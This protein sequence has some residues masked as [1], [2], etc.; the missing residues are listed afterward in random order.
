MTRR[1]EYQKMSHNYKSDYEYKVIENSIMNLYTFIKENKW[2]G[3][4]PYDGLNSKFTSFVST[5]SKWMRI[6]II[7][8]NKE[9]PINF[10]RALGIKK[11]MNIKGMG[12][13]ALAFIKLY[14]LTGDTELL[15]KAHFCLDFLKTKSLKGNYSG[16]CWSGCYV[17]QSR[18]EKYTPKNPDII[19]TVVCASAFLEDYGTTGAEES[20]EIAK[21]SANFIVDTLFIN[22]D[23][24]PFFKYTPLSEPN[25][26][27]YN[28]SAY[29][30]MVLS[31]INKHIKIKDNK[32]LEITKKVM[33]YII[34]KQKSNGAWYYSE[35]DGNER[36]QID[37]HQGFILDGLYD[38]IKY[39][40]PNDDKYMK[41]LIKGAEFYKKEQ[42]FLD[43][44]CKYRWPRVY[45]IDIH[46]QAQGIITFS[47]LSEI[48]P[49]YPDFAKT[50]ALWTI[51]N[52][53]DESGY[54]YYQ[55]HRFYMNKIP[56]MRWGQA[57]MMLALT[58]LLEAM[59]NGK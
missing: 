1:G 13:F 49:E 52:M 35:T 11:G 3:Y 7:Q 32:N 58:S 16:H 28:P 15:K 10:R 34:S 21:S 44:R 30:V 43:G 53:Q 20:L 50:I 59:E 24:K 36:M 29:A 33:D 37:Y 55:K 9:S 17:Y 14:K 5:K 38:L 47:K 26:I 31:N 8:F 39:T 46:N 42:F 56:Y 48:K 54:F 19:N 23:K 22:N 57:W 6:F 27:V 51:K 40:K 25:T 12:L 45:P 18:N 4:D 2:K 41:S